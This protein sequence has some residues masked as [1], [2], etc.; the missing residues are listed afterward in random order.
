MPSKGVPPSRTTPP[1]ASMDSANPVQE[2]A[3]RPLPPPAPPPHQHRDSNL[4]DSMPPATGPSGS[5]RSP[6]PSEPCGSPPKPPPRTLPVGRRSPAHRAPDLPGPEGAYPIAD[7]PGGSRH[8]SC[9]PCPA[10]STT[11]APGQGHWETSSPN[12]PKAG[13]MPIHS[14]RP[15]SAEPCHATTC[16]SPQDAKP[17]IQDR[18]VRNAGCVEAIPLLEPPGRSFPCPCR[19]SNPSLSRVHPESTPGVRSRS[20]ENR[21][22]T[23]PRPDRHSGSPA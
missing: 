10:A 8:P 16:W 22:H 11:H 1:A 4:P 9:A 12:P 23:T 20:G 6:S 19:P 5:D 15:A 2:P 13:R 3:T 18:S 14:I 21:S 17:R 7:V